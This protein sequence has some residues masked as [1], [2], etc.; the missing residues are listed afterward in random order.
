M[1]HDMVT[2][3]CSECKRRN[4]S[5]RKNNKAHPERMEYWRHYDKHTQHREMR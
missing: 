3:A 1:S 4:Y 2:L 5:T